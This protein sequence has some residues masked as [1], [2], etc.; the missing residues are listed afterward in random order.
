[1]FIDHSTKPHAN[2]KT[3]VD[4]DG[5]FQMEL[6]FSDFANHDFT[7]YYNGRETEVLI[8]VKMT[9]H[10][11]PD[12]V[13]ELDGKNAENFKGPFTYQYDRLDELYQKVSTSVY[14]DIVANQNVYD[15]LTLERIELPNEYGDSN[16]WIDTE[17]ITDDHKYFY[18]PGKF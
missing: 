16:L 17:V 3:S 12:E 1:M 2:E 7:E 13:K 8:E 9:E 10:S 18:N 4:E 15:I 5:S 6:V 14:V 11:Q